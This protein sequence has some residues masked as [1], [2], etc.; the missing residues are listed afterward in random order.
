MKRYS[1]IALKVQLEDPVRSTIPTPSK[2]APSAATEQVGP[3][4]MEEVAAASQSDAFP[5]TRA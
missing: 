1:A 3:A 2:R 4:K 5:A